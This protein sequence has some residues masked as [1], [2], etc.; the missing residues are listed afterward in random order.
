MKHEFIIL[1]LLV[2]SSSVVAQTKM[3]IN[4]NNGTTDS[5]L[6]SEIKSISFKSGNSPAPTDPVLVHILGGTFSMGGILNSI[7]QP[8]HS[9]TLDSF[10]IDMYEVT[11]EHWTTVRNW[12]LTHGYADI[13][14]GRNGN[15]GTTS[16]P[17][18]EVSWYDVVKWCNARSEMDG[19]TAV[20]YEDSTQATAYR[21][22]ALD[23]TNGSVK[24]SANGF[25]LP[26]EAEWECA[27]R[28]GTHQ[29]AS[30]YS[31]SAD[32][33]TVAWYAGN[34][35]GNTHPVGGL[36]ANELGLHDM[37]GNVYEWCWDRYGTYPSEAQTNP[38]GPTSGTNRVLRGGAFSSAFATACRV[39][40]RVNN[41]LTAKYPS[42]GFRCVQH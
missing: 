9:V 15:Q 8:I 41:T 33:N 4:K 24:L 27:A 26:T 21:T 7:E 37:S 19:L 25:R 13:P 32:I 1:S 16:H 28:G 14:V 12:G 23:I 2:V 22:G 30:E 3:F 31:G 18:T 42:G 5:L 34:S 10:K 38:L 35:A 40:S 20:Y 36:A 39:Y 11:Y 29:N 6:L 17:V